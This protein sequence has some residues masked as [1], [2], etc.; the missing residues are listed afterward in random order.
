MRYIVTL[1]LYNGVIH[2]MRQRPFALATVFVVGALSQGA[3]F[4]QHAEE[5]EI[6]VTAPL[7]GSRIESLQGAT[8]LG[9]E[10]IVENLARGLGDTLDS[11]PGVATTFFGAGA[12]RPIIRG[13]GEDRVRVLQNGIGAIDASTA[14][15]DH[16]VTADGLD[17]ERIEVLRGAAALAYGG[18]AIGGV[19]N[20]IDQSIPSRANH[21]LSGGALLSASSVDAGLSGAADLG[22]GAGP[23]QLR[24][25]AAA[26]QGDPYQTPIGEA[27]N[28]YAEHQAYAGGAALV[29]VWGFAGVALKRTEDEYGLLPADPSELGGH[30][31]LEQTR[32]EA[33]G[34]MRIEIGPFDR[35]DFAGQHSDYQ[36]TEFEADGAAGARFLS[37][38]Y[39]ARV[40]IH[41]RAGPHQG[42]SGVQLTDV[43]FAA[44][45]AEA[46]ITPTSTSDIGL[47]ALERW[48]QG[49]WG[50]E[51]GARV[52]RRSHENLLFG[53]REFDSFSAS[54]GAFV[55]PTESWFIGATLAHTERAPTAVELFADGPH[56]ATAN[57]EIGD[58]NLSQEIAAS[59]EASARFDQDGARF[60]FNLFAIGF[61]DYIA[62]AARGDV[63]W[64]DEL[65]ETSGFAA[66]ETDPGIPAGATILPVFQIV[67][68]DARFVGGE[69][70]FRA[71]LGDIAG[72]TFSGDAALD[73]VNAAFDGG[74]HPPR[75]PPRALT[76]GLEAE[77]PH[78]SGRIEAVN[79]ARQADLAAFETATEGYTFLNAGFAFRPAGADSPVTLRLDARNLGDELG[80]VHASFLKN[81][82]PLPGRNLRLALLAR[83]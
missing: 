56:L 38:G 13:L 44:I 72:F 27:P 50:L 29:G 33:R 30:I 21:G 79:T 1:L 40:E 24:L 51:G 82:L 39:E 52:E 53:A 14:S 59:F 34:D 77:S 80:R 11:Q 25:S 4:A 10:D 17:A 16:A 18:N 31:E 83:F 76:L 71:R 20:V 5:D 69:V 6:V 23:A 36:H 67:Q 28:Q 15:P 41:H 70:F 63:F 48:D 19:V 7:E 46:F 78:W 66:S 64:L 58:P 2:M 68:R 12:S 9:R 26:R 37:E 8:A 65:T 61:A 73:L 62:L 75:I 42:V 22:F 54:L 35:L 47:F 81:A 3:A 57:Y 32:I 60:E 45:G 49:G 43:D 74:G 55:R